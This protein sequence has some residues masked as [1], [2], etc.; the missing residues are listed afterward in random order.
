MSGP[1]TLLRKKSGPLTSE[2]LLKPNDFGLGMLPRNLETSATT[3]SVCGFCSTGCQLKI[4]LDD[5]EAAGLTPAPNYPV[6]LGMACPKGWEAL[7]VLDSPDR[8]TTPLLHGKEISWQKAAESFTTEFKKVQ[9]K[10]GKESVAFISTG[11]IPT[12]EMAFLGSFAKF[13]MGVKHG[14]GNTR[15][16]MATSVVAYKQA[17]GFDA[18][19]YTYGD[20]EESDV[21]LLIGSNLAIAHPILYQRLARNKRNPDI[22]VIDPRA[23]ETAQIATDHLAIKPKGD[24]YLLYTLAHCLV[25]DNSINHEFLEKHTEGFEEFSKFV[26]EY[27]PDATFEKTGI[28]HRQIEDLAKLI[29]DPSKRVSMWWT[30]GVNQSHE[31]VRT[32]QAIINLCLMTGNIGK[33]GTGPNS[34]TGQCNAMGSRLFSNTTSLLGGHDFGNPKHRA[35]VSGILDIPEPNIP[36]E[37]SWAYDQIIE[38]I[39]TGDIK[40]LWIIATNP[41]HSWINQDRFTKLREKLDFLVVQDMYAT[42]E[43]ARTADLLLPAASWGEKNGTFINSERRIGTLKQVRKAPGKALSDFRIF[44]LLAHT[45]GVGDLFKKWTEPETVFGLLQQLSAGQPCDI[46]GI[47]GYQDLDQSGGIQWPKT[48]ETCEQERRLFSDGKF[49]TPSGKAR[50][51]F[52]PPA[53]LPEPTSNEFPFTLMTG[54][55]TSAQWHTQSRTQKSVVLRKLYPA[56]LLLDLNP[57]DAASLG[58]KDRDPVTISSKRASITALAHLTSSVNPGEVY[59]PMHEP[60]VNRLTFPAFDP[61]SRQPSYKACAVNVTL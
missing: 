40:G 31:G 32:A 46:T 57:A 38:G 34:I 51:L 44:Q 10:H 7:A 3:T 37:A 23:T 13:G 9:E 15:Q 56:A 16:C 8:A 41:A 25:R 58:I 27:S 1:N 36:T 18:P 22:I 12:E 24:L 19:P 21:V 26:A 48:T 61:H 29:S 6:N 5:G 47:Q 49:H 59:L 11:Q 35:K 30:M 50:F 42:T 39:E 2:L 17:F 60:N 33:P 43:T 28:A 14:D 54:R 53:P 55:G 20:F 45:W 4:H 52:D